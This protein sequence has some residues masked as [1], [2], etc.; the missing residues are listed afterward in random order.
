M[1][2]TKAAAIN[3]Q[4]MLPDDVASINSLLVAVG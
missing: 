4:A 3:T 1:N 2:S